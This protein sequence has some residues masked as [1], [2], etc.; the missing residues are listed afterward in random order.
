[1]TKSTKN[2]R[3]E[4][5]ITTLKGEYVNL[6]TA[7]HTPFEITVP[8]V[9]SEKLALDAAYTALNL[10][11]TYIIDS[12]KFEIVNEKSIPVR[13]SNTKLYDNRRDIFA[14][15]DEAKAACLDGETVKSVSLYT[16]VSNAWT[17][18][19]IGTYHTHKVSYETPVNI[20]K[21]DARAFVKMRFEEESDEMVLALHDTKKEETS[22]FVV[23]EEEALKRCIIEKKH[24]D[25]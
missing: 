15:E 25:K 8:Y 19:N 9:R 10:D 4:G 6:D 14:T 21:S 23:I 18:D 7:E 11:A 5:K 22:F 20:T 1:M 16:V 12:R 17:L 13:Y 24:D 3:F 2:T